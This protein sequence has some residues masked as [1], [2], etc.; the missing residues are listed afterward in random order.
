M[1]YFQL[2]MECNPNMIDSLFTP[3]TCVLHSTRI[4]S[5]VRENRRVFLHKGAWH[6]FK[7]YAY[8]QVHKMNS[9]QPPEGKRRELVAAYGFDVK[10]AYHV[11]R[12]LDEVE[13]I[14]TDGDIDLQR[15]RE[16]LKA[17]RRGEWT[18]EDIRN[19][20]TRKER[21]L[22]TLY[23]GSKLPAR[24]TRPRSSVCCWIAWRRTTAAS[25][26][27]WSTWTPRPRRCATSGP[28]WTARQ[29]KKI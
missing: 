20:F 8:S 18:Q 7:G 3:H 11:V 4:G 25:P 5:L 28:S 6:K 10:Y 26:I 1:K 9:K 22:E 14:L 21:E 13:Q 16:Q 23:T 19:Y 24:P 29:N 12:L 27:A 15:N 2:C 17:I